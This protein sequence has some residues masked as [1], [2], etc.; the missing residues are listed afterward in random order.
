M[1]TTNNSLLP[2]LFYNLLILTV[3]VIL[4]LQTCT[5]TLKYMCLRCS[6][7][8]KYPESSAMVGQMF[9]LEQALFRIK[10]LQVQCHLIPSQLQNCYRLSILKILNSEQNQKPAGLLQRNVAATR[11]NCSIRFMQMLGFR[12]T[13]LLQVS[14]VS[15]VLR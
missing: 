5:C 2:F 6:L 3:T 14:L 9:Y 1:Y 4:H 12:L 15:L 10:Q 13:V 8:E 7:Y 11:F